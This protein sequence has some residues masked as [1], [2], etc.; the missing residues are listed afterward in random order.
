MEQAKEKL[1][2]EVQQ[3]MD[4]YADMVGFISKRLNRALAG[5]GAGIAIVIANSTYFAA[6]SDF[7]PWVFLFCLLQFFA[8]VCIS[9]ATD[10]KLSSLQIAFQ[11]SHYNAREAIAELDAEELRS[12]RHKIKKLRDGLQKSIA[13]SSVAISFLAV[14]VVGTFVATVL[15]ELQ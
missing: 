8:A 7:H 3:V 1:K 13:Y 11:I 15:V 12:T 10:L 2:E 5:S 6:E 14:G 4:L 9:F